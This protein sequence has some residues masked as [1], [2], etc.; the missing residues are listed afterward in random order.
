MPNL[1]STVSLVNNPQACRS[2][3]SHIRWRAPLLQEE[4]FQLDVSRFTNRALALNHTQRWR[5]IA[6]QDLL[7]SL[8]RFL[9]TALP[10]N[11][12][13]QYHCCRKRLPSQAPESVATNSASRLLSAIVDCFLLDAVIG[14]QPSLPRNHDAVPFT[15][16]RSASPAQSASLYVNTEPTG[17][18]FTASRLSVVG[19]TSKA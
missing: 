13:N 17:A 7:C 5:R 4:R 8:T 10:P 2:S 9:G 1:V 11:F 12:T 14:Y 18:L 15:L 6:A 19:R 3:Q 16:N